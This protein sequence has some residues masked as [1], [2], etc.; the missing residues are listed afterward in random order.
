MRVCIE[1]L[2]ERESLIDH[3]C[4]GSEQPNGNNDGRDCEGV[5]AGEC[6]PLG[7]RH[8][9]SLGRFERETRVLD[10]EKVSRML[11]FSLRS[12]PCSTV[13]S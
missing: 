7:C 2:G 4:G 10:K 9:D 13:G 1:E 8:L 11:Y 6:H 12:D 3:L 5:N